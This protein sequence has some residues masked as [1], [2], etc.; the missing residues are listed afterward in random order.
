[1]SFVSCF[2]KIFCRVVA[3]ADVKEDNTELVLK[4]KKLSPSTAASSSSSSSSVATAMD[5]PQQTQQQQFLLEAYFRDGS[6]AELMP[7]TFK[8]DV[9]QADT[10]TVNTLAPAAAACSSSAHSSSS[11]GF[12]VYPGLIAHSAPAD[13]E[14]AYAFFTRF[15]SSP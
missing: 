3:K 12:C 4:W 7:L 9:A 2:S 6:D 10:W 5:T 11:S 15:Q 13:R 8:T 14:D 1:M